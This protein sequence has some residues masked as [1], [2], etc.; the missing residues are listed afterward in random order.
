MKILS[1]DSFCEN[2]KC[3]EL[4][5]DESS[6]DNSL[7]T[8]ALKRVLHNVI[9]NEL[10][11]RQ[12]EIVMLYYFNNKNILEISRELGLNKST[13]SRHL[14]RARDKIERVLRYGYFPIWKEVV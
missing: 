11:E 13:V 10:T 9:D 1:L 8:A 3:I 5:K 14:Q 12:K 4:F 7:Q 6:G 2:T